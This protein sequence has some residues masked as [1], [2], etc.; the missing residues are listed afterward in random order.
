[1]NGVYIVIDASHIGDAF[2]DERLL[3]EAPAIG[4]DEEPVEL[5]CMLIFLVFHLYG[6]LIE[7]KA[8]MVFHMDIKARKYLKVNRCS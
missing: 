7:A 5:L 2:M 1:M 8:P 3:G 4:V 6:E